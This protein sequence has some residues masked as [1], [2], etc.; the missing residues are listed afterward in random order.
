MADP[1]ETLKQTR[2]WKPA[3]RKYA[4]H[5]IAHRR[6]KCQGESMSFFAFASDILSTPEKRRDDLLKIEGPEAAE[7]ARLQNA[8]SVRYRQYDP[9]PPK[10]LKIG[11]T[12]LPTKRRR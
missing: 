7:L 1:I 2:W 3:V 8:P 11:L 4:E 5:L 12:L 10:E 6:Q 9:P